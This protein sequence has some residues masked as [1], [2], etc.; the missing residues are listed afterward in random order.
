[1]GQVYL[2]RLGVYSHSKTVSY[3]RNPNVSI[4]S[5]EC[6][7]DFDIRVSDFRHQQRKRKIMEIAISPTVHHFYPLAN[8]AARTRTASA[9]MTAT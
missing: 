7:S 5:F 9:V 1:M 3:T 4:W 6:V 8:I 2:M